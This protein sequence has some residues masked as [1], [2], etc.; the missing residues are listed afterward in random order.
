MTG[1]PQ[2]AN[3]SNFKSFVHLQYSQGGSLGCS[4]VG[5]I[6]TPSSQE[7]GVEVGALFPA[8]LSQPLWQLTGGAGTT[9]IFWSCDGKVQM[10][11]GGCRVQEHQLH[12]ITRELSELIPGLA[13]PQSALSS[14]LYTPP[15]TQNN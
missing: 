14:C 10:F 12:L 4:S 6:W 5:C 3:L 11:L 15:P 9:G 7:E 13:L 2:V 1:L 8:P